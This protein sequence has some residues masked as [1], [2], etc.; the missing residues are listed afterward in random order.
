[1]ICPSPTIHRKAKKGGR[2]KKKKEGQ[3]HAAAT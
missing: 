2:E 3:G 1:L